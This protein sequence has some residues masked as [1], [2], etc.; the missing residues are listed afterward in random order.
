MLASLTEQKYH[1]VLTLSS[2]FLFLVRRGAE[3]F[4]LPP[5]ST[6]DEYIPK[7]QH[8]SKNDNNN[9]NN[10]TM[11]SP[12]SSFSSSSTTSPSS[13]LSDHS[14][15]LIQHP[16]S[17]PRT[18]FE[19]MDTPIYPIGAQETTTSTPNSLGTGH[20]NNSILRTV[21]S[22]VDQVVQQANSLCDNMAHY[23]PYLLSASTTS[24]HD[25]ELRPWMDSMIGKAN[26][27]LNA[28][29]R[30]RKQQMVSAPSPPPH[31]NLTPSSDHQYQQ[32]QQHSF[33][34]HHPQPQPP[35]LPSPPSSS[36]ITITK[37]DWPNSATQQHHDPTSMANSRTS[38]PSRQRKR[39]KRSNFQGRC[40][41]C[42]IS[43]TPEWRRGPDGA[44]TLCNACGLRKSYIND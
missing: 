33:T 15:V 19:K 16:P 7:H 31:T 26:E 6:L 2:S 30:L 28:L 25:D 9:S 13:S 5:I 20:H 3:R 24:Q 41:S 44:R 42:N 18:A 23:K 4:V 27:V 12:P 36:R 8:H 10:F 35:S 38:I 17:P 43:E 34:Y 1:D 29:L 32:Q 11:L 40:H 14:T 21:S 37:R 39:G 22:D